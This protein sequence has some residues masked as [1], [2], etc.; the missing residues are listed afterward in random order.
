[1]WVFSKTSIK[2]RDSLGFERIRRNRATSSLGNV[3]AR[4][5]SEL[6]IVWECIHLQL[7]IGSDKEWGSSEVEV[8][9]HKNDPECAAGRRIDHSI[10]HIANWLNHQCCIHNLITKLKERF[11]LEIYLNSETDQICHTHATEWIVFLE[12]K[13]TISTITAAARRHT[14]LARTLPVFR[15]AYSNGRNSSSNVTIAI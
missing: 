6:A 8:A 10:C 1:M 7:R 9:H 12:I 11:I 14:S 2:L 5:R 4:S 15:I 13:E 3:L